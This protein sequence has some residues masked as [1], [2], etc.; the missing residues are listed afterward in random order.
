MVTGQNKK[1]RRKQAAQAS[2]SAPCAWTFA[3]VQRGV[4]PLPPPARVSPFAPQ[5]PR[6]P[7]APLPAA[8]GGSTRAPPRGSRARTSGL[9]R[10]PRPS[11][12]RRHRHHP[13]HH[14][15][16]QQLQLQLQLQNDQ[17]RHRH[18]RPGQR[19][20]RPGFGG[21][22]LSRGRCR[23]WR[24]TPPG[25]PPPTARG[26]YSARSLK[27]NTQPQAQRQE[28]TRRRGLRAVEKR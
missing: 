4:G 26:T 22:R 11:K 20:R 3:Y 8:P 10:P 7:R 5:P 15:H 17:T 12:H 24:G 13:H 18:Q 21:A 25:R 16:H 2:A 23:V 14:H 28:D 9:S 1:G 27:K 6:W 19:R